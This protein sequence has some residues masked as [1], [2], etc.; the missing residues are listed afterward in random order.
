MMSASMVGL[1]W[2]SRQLFEFIEIYC[3]IFMIA[4]VRQIDIKAKTSLSLHVSPRFDI[5]Q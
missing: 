4:S 5:I 1:G 2:A 3:S